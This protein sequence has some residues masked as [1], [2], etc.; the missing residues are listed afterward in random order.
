MT[1]LELFELLNLHKLYAKLEKKLY[2]RF[3]EIV[4]R[5]LRADFGHSWIFSSISRQIK[6][7]IFSFQMK[8]VLW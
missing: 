1:K 8:D 6:L 7:N 3:Q 5:F 2:E 4:I